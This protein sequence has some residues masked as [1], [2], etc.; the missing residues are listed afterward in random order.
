MTKPPMK[1]LTNGI[2][3]ADESNI[4]TSTDILLAERGLPPAKY[5]AFIL[6]HNEDIEFATLLVEKLEGYGLTVIKTI[7]YF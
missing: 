4:L 5:D 7:T 1:Y 2:N 6:F 3:A